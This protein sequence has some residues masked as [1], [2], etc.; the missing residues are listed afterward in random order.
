MAILDF[1]DI[2]PDNEEWTLRYSTLI[3]RSDLNGAEQTEELPGARWSV[4]VTFSNRQG[5]DVRALQGFLA[6]LKGRAG[7]FWYVP[8][9]WEPLGTAG[10]TPTSSAGVNEGDTTMA[11]TGW[12]ANQNEALAIGDY[13]EYNGELKK[14]T[15][16]VTSDGAGD[17]T[18]EFAPP[19]RIA[20]GSGL[21][22]TLTEPRCQMKLASDT[23]GKWNIRAPTIYASTLNFEEVLV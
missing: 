12:T 21:S 8:S 6:S 22:L 2:V 14:V 17:A 11:T 1:P 7:R 19:I 13:F 16:T 20:T 15:A 4:Q 5:R 3:F 23:E 9:D 10:G 18:V